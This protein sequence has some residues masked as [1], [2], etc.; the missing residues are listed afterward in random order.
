MHNTVVSKYRHYQHE[1]QI[2]RLSA[3]NPNTTIVSIAHDL[4]AIQCSLL[5]RVWWQCGRNDCHRIPQDTQRYTHTWE[6]EQGQQKKH[7]SVLAYFACL[8]ML[9]IRPQPVMAYECTYISKRMSAHTFIDSESTH[10]PYPA[11]HLSNWPVYQ[12]EDFSS[13][14]RPVYRLL[15]G[16]FTDCLLGFPA[17]FAVMMVGLFTDLKHA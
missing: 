6:S 14:Q 15:R 1:T 3:W 2:S 12:N 9:R 8:Q 7:G 16:L 13:T 10:V 11:L 4:E 17:T 5:D